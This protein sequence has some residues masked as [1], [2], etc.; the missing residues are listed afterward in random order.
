M[1]IRSAAVAGTF[2]PGDPKTLEA[3]VQEFMDKAP[4]KPAP[5]RVAAIVAPHAGYV[6]SGPT[7]GFAYKHI[8]GMKPKRVIVLGGSHRYRLEKASVW[9]SGAFETPL[10]H[11][12]IDEAFAQAFAEETG[13]DSVDPHFGEHGLE[14]QLP[15]IQAALGIIPIVPVLFGGRARDWHV[16]MG[17]KLAELAGDSSLVI[18]STDLSHFM[19]EDEANAIDKRTLDALVKLDTA[20]LI[21]GLQTGKYAMCGESAVLAA[22]GYAL[23]QGATDGVLLDYRTSAAASGDY[24]RVVGY[25]A[26]SMER[27]E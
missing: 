21:A 4:V 18:A 14:V 24:G 5:D 17:R 19:T 12:P 7:A 8:C 13:S 20:A 10:G 6:Y 9:I 22:I 27:P 23:E 2:Y 26:V 16:A 11:F 25:G 3:M 1:D 15:F